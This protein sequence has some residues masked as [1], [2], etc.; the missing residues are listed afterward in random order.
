MDYDSLFDVFHTEK[1]Q[2]KTIDCC[3]NNDNYSLHNGI[4][5]CKK[6][7]N[8]LTCPHCSIFLT[9]HKHINK[10][11]CHHCGFKKNTKEC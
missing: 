11:L 10:A 3:D 7:G 4:I 8:K 6:C 5:I 1:T 2:N 9:F